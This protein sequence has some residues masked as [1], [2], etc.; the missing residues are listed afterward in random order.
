MSAIIE[1]T[2]ELLEIFAIWGGN[3]TLYLRSSQAICV[4]QNFRHYFDLY[5][6]KLVS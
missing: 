4:A 1:K 2:W 3:G 6:K 5:S